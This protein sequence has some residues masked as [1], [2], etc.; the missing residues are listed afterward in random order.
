MTGTENVTTSAFL[1]LKQMMIALINKLFSWLFTSIIKPT[2]INNDVIVF[3]DEDIMDID[4]LPRTTNKFIN[5]ITPEE[6]KQTIMEYKVKHGV[7]AGYT[8]GE[9]LRSKNLTDLIFEVDTTDFFV[10]KV[11]RGVEALLTCSCKCT[12]RRR[13]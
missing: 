12:T 6:L 7:N 9:I 10:H 3:D 1:R 4:S 2:V 8:I 5:Y 11:W 13:I